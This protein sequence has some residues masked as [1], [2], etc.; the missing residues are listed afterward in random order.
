MVEE[1]CSHR[2]DRNNTEEARH[3]ALAGP[4]LVPVAH[5]RIREA[6]DHGDECAVGADGHDVEE[7]ARDV[8]IPAGCDGTVLGLHRAASL[9]AEDPIQ[10]QAGHRERTFPVRTVGEAVEAAVVGVGADVEAAGH[11]D[12][13]HAD[14]EPWAAGLPDAVNDVHAHEAAGGQ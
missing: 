4:V 2:A 11:G 8:R 14:A 1:R 5:R 7:G 3:N 10:E 12:I 13:H 9:A 6:A